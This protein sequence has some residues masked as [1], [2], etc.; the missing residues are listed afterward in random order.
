[1]KRKLWIAL[2]ALA[3]IVGGSALAIDHYSGTHF[4]VA[5]DGGG[6]M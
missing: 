3:L 6:G 5:D 1:M 4:L 2:T